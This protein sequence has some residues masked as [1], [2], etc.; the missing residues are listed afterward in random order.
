MPPIDVKE[1]AKALK[2]LPFAGE[3]E[4]GEA[5][6]ALQKYPALNSG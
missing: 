2:A 6:C 3:G 1:T 4:C 5:R